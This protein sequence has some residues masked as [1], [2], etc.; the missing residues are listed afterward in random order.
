MLSAILDSFPAIIALIDPNGK[1][2]L[3]NSHWRETAVARQIEAPNYGIGQSY[4]S[5]F[6]SMMGRHADIQSIAAAIRNTIDGEP[7]ASPIKYPIHSDEGVRWFELKPTPLSFQGQ[8]FALVAHSDITERIEYEHKL[9]KCESHLRE[10][11][12]LAKTGTSVY[13]PAT[14]LLEWT[15]ETYLIFGFDPAAPPPSREELFRRIHP[16]DNN[17][18][19]PLYQRALS[20][21]ESFEMDLR[22]VSSYTP[23]KWVHVIVNPQTDDHN[24]VTHL[25]TVVMDITENKLLEERLLRTQSLERVGRLA[26]GVA[27]EFN[28]ILTAI[29]GYAEM[30]LSELTP[31]SPVRNYI[32]QINRAATRAAHLTSQLLSFASKQIISCRVLNLNDLLRKFLPELTKSLGSTISVDVKLE[33]L[34]WNIKADA[35]QLHEAIMEITLNSKDSMPDGGLLIIETS[36]VFVDMEFERY[37]PGLQ[38]G[39]YVML[40]INDTGKGM[41]RETQLSVFDPF[42]TT[43]DFGSGHGLG[44]AAAYGII[45][46]HGGYIWLYSEPGHGSTFKILLPRCDEPLDEE[47][48]CETQPSDSGMETIFV[49]L[50]QDML[51]EITA[52][53]LRTKGY[54]VLE[55]GSCQTALN[56]LRKFQA[57]IK[58]MISDTL[59]TG[60]NERELRDYIQNHLSDI[61]ILHLSSG[62]NSSITESVSPHVTLLHLEMP[63]S[64]HLLLQKVREGLGEKRNR[65]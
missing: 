45:R 33:K 17:K 25:A 50:R 4:L 31:F 35:E 46:Q 5:M 29:E 41:S 12:R 8:R 1:I 44:L 57:P 53:T 61:R 39:N 23:T 58:M 11:Q 2:V 56:T 63:F 51:R 27:H 19:Q 6:E 47:K 10:A 52:T 9:Q 38:S 16:E 49:L 18:Y 13:C 24:Q 62:P 28:N 26:G 37:H 34:P 22:V 14:G 32:L 60:E 43:G 21:G 30:S 55:A 36:N 7:V 15:E 3:V 59:F 20:T 40:A 65:N 54:T 48:A 42:F 64:A